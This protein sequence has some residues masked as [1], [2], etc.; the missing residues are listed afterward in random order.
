M[1]ALA[2][3]ITIFVV[4]HC[5]HLAALRH[6]VHGMH[7]PMLQRRFSFCLAK[8]YAEHRDCRGPRGQ[9]CAATL[10]PMQIMQSSPSLCNAL[11]GAVQRLGHSR[12]LNMLC[13]RR[14]IYTAATKTLV[15]AEQYYISHSFNCKTPWATKVRAG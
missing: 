4:S 14:Y 3:L 15:F 6:S 1:T 12:G 8:E 11:T 7:R 2:H 13:A 9:Q 5:P 10:S